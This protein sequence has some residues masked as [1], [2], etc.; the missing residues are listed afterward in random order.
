MMPRPEVF[1]SGAVE[2]LVDEA[3]VNRLVRHVRAEAASVY[4][5]YGKEKLRDSVPGYNNAAPC[6]R[7]LTMWPREA[8]L[9]P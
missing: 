8:T 2:G 9:G 5:A 1:I 6:A 7:A 4:V 3:L